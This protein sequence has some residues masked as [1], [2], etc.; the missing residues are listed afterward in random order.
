[1]IFDDYGNP[2]ALLSLYNGGVAGF[3]ISTPADPG[4]GITV[5]SGGIVTGAWQHVAGVYDGSEIR[6]YINGLLVGSAPTSGS[7]ID[8]GTMPA[9]V[10]RDDVSPAL[11]FN[12]KMDDLRIFNA[13]L[14][15][16]ELSC[17]PEPSSSL[18]M[19]A[20]FLTLLTAGAGNRLFPRRKPRPKRT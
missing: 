10:G 16:D 3:G 8:N 11:Y 12:G 14:S 6:L 4:L 20:G 18:L 17:A 7:I 15:P 13:A 19:V 5:T 1:V 9:G 2:G